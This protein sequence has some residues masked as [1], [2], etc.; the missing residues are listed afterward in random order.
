ME[1]LG[2]YCAIMLKMVE[3]SN[4]TAQ[5]IATLGMAFLTVAVYNGLGNHLQDVVAA[6][7]IIPAIKY[8]WIADAMISLAIGVG[9]FSVVAY[10]TGIQGSTH[11]WRQRALV[12][13][14][15]TNVS[16]GQDC[17]CSASRLTSGK[18][19][20]NIVLV[21]LIFFQC[22]PP[23][24]LWDKSIEGVCSLSSVNMYYGIAGGGG[25]YDSA[26]S[27]D[28]IAADLV[29]RGTLPRILCSHSTPSA[30]CTNYR[31]ARS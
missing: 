26:S 2:E 29:Q 16:E 6:G 13:L 14:A 23:A 21:F 24:S 30:S 1:R 18:L 9:K 28:S 4:V 5:V 19:A 17:Y 31:C 15:A 11:I 7:T 8:Q 25:F 12:L 27:S 22:S 20:N 3:I 10:Y